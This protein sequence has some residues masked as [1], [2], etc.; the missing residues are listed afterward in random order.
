M[1]ALAI[2]LV[3]AVVLH[4][5]RAPC[6]GTF[7]DLEGQPI[8]GAVVTFVQEWSQRFGCEP[9]RVEVETDAAGTFA[10]ELLLGSPYVVWAIGSPNAVGKRWLTG[11]SMDAAGGKRIELRAVRRAAPGQVE[12]RGVSA[13]MKH[14]PPAVRVLVGSYYAL[15]PDRPVGADGTLT[16]GPWPD[17]EA[18]LALVDDKREILC[19]SSPVVDPA[20]AKAAPIVE[21]L[22]PRAI[23]CV[24]V[25]AEGAPVAGADL[26]VSVNAPSWWLNAADL[27]PGLYRPVRRHAG[28]TDAAGKATIYVPWAADPDNRSIHVMATH[29]DL[30]ASMSGIIGDERFHDLVPAPPDDALLFR[31]QAGAAQQWVWRGL[32]PTGTAHAQMATFFSFNAG[33]VSGA[34]DFGVSLAV[35]D[36]VSSAHAVSARS[37]AHVYVRLHG[38]GE[39]PPER[40]AFGAILRGQATVDISALPQVSIAILTTQGVPVP[41]AHVG[42]IERTKGHPQRWHD[43]C[44]A[45]ARGQLR[46]RATLGKDWIVLATDGSGFGAV[47]LDPADNANRTKL[48]LRPMRVAELVVTDIDG[49]PLAE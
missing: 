6:S 14:V 18:V 43:R 31:L 16:L 8:A 41:F 5:Q 47:A 39:L 12:L 27:L 45:D 28:R 48:V 24:V 3:T 49:V 42:I 20:L 34:G 36:G 13:W 22:R 44:V 4:A 10:G 23:E 2:L 15:G 29:P 7:V 19:H 21:F 46:V 9:D 40:V 35:R 26:E 30:G 32:G 1:R 38:V 37:V 33:R 25:D 17:V 11:V